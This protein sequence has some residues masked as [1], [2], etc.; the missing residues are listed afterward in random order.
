MTGILPAKEECLKLLEE[1]GCNEKVIEHC[2]AVTELAV[3]IAKLAKADLELVECGALLH[4][5]GR[6]K[7]HE[8][9]HAVLGA[10]MVRSMG[11]PEKI[12]LIIERHIGAGLSKDEAASF[13]LPERDY[14]PQTLEEKIVAHSDNLIEENK[15]RPVSDLFMH[16]AGLGYEKVAN[17][18][19][20]LH[21][22]LSEIC[23]LDL[24]E[25]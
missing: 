2:L 19:L 11:L 9:E 24:D 10:E 14:T 18:I 16:F 25:I 6:S 22:E 20:A 5:I 3:R 15:K 7:S 23:A 17:N 1:A 13:G 8:I 4:D 21:K 12:A